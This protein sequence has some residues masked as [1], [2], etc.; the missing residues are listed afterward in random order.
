VSWE[1][2]AGHRHIDTDRRTNA[3]LEHA[4]VHA[5]VAL[6][7]DARWRLVRHDDLLECRA[8]RGAPAR[9]AVAK[10]KGMSGKRSAGPV[11]NRGVQR[12]A[13]VVGGG[14][15][16]Q[17]IAAA[18]GEQTKSKPARQAVKRWSRPSPR[19][20]PVSAQPTSKRRAPRAACTALAPA[21]SPPS[22]APRRAQLAL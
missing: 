16:K 17:A 9:L 10:T 20:T 21:D 4:A 14:T 2:Q 7:L 11:Q 15:H 1:D 18:R 3:N 22:V 8:A 6:Q 5:E 12:A 13:P 19:V